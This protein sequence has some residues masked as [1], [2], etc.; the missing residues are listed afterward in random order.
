MHTISITIEES[1]YKRLKKLIPP[2]KISKF[3]SQAI[4]HELECQDDILLKAYKEAYSD[5]S[6]LKALEEW[7]ILDGEE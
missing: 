2:G 6:R 3:I 1:I 4:K 7:S 5:K